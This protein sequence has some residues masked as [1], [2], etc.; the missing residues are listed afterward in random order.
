MRHVLSLD[1]D[2]SIAVQNA[3]FKRAKAISRR[4]ANIEIQA[5]REL[6]DAKSERSRTDATITYRV[7]GAHVQLRVRAWEDRW[8]WI[9]IRRR[10]KVGWVW[11]YTGEGR[12]ISSKGARGLVE[13]AEET[14]A[15]SFL[16]VEK[17]PAAIERLWSKCLALGPRPA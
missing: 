3:F 2:F 1:A 9:D 12:F 5:I 10:S 16:A 17:L 7:D 11:E 13:H 15:A 14:M 6:L 4:G 8:V